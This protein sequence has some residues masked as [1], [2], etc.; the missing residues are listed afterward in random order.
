MTPEGESAAYV[1][2]PYSIGFAFICCLEELSIQSGAD[3]E[4][5]QIA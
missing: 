2:L 1:K 4:I 3:A 5:G